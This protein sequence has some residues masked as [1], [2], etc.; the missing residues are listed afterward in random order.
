MSGK[1]DSLLS[2]MTLEEKTSMLAGAD[3][4]HT[5]PVE[6][7]GIPAIKVSDG[8]IGARGANES[9]GPTSAAFP[10]GVALAATWNPA[11][12]ERVG[13]ALAQ[14]VKA[15]GAHI[16]LAPT[17]NI[18]R[19]PLAGR[20]FECYSE[21]P[22]L[23][24]RMA[25]AY[26]MG[27]Q[28]QGVGACI[29]HFV[30]N[31]S[32]FERLT[33]SS[34]VGERALREIYLRPFQIAL[35]EAH[36]WAVM[37][38]YNKINGTWAS[39]NDYTLLDILKGEWGFDGL[40]ISDWFGTNTPNVVR[41]GLDLEMPGPAR[42]MG[43]ASGAVKTGAV[44]EAAIDDKVRRL[45]RTLERAGA[46]E[47]PKLEAEQA[48]DRPEHRQLAREA[49]AEAIVLLKNHADILPIDLSRRGSIAVIGAN[50]HWAAVMGGGSAKV[51]P[52]YVVTPLEG[53]RQ[54]TGAAKVGYAIG[55][56][57][58]KNPPLFDAAWLRSE[59]NAQGLTVRYFD[60]RVLIGEPVHTAVTS[61][62]E[63]VWFG[64]KL[65]HINDTGN[66]SL[67]LNGTFVAP[68]AGVYILSLASV[69]Q[70]RLFLDGQP[71]IDLWEAAAAELQVFESTA[72]TAEVTLRAGQACRLVVEFAAQPGTIWRNLRLGCMPP[73]PADPLGEAMA[74][75]RDSDVAIVFAGLTTEWESEGYDRPDMALPGDQARLIEAV[76]VANPRTIVVLNSGAPV[77]MGWLDKVA[78]VLQAWYPG[79]EAG[80]AIADVLFGDVN[81]SGKLPTTFPVRLEDTPAYINYPGENGR[82]LYGEGLFVGYRYYDKK[83][84]TPLFPFGHGLSY[85]SF[86][87]RNLSLP[88]PGYAAGLPIRLSVDVENI[89]AR[90][91]QEVVQVYIRDV[92]S[93]LVRPEKELK[94][95]AKVRLAPGET[96]TVTFTLDEDALAYYDPSQPGWVTEA[97]EFEVLVGSSSRDIRL[98]G[99]FEVEL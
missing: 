14:E 21:D 36:P 8:P 92:R 73:L 16:L 67:R 80:N 25:T 27:L 28:S 22:Y 86:A 74:L 57:M 5:T 2:R 71:I 24:G 66:F 87:Y 3:L 7:L 84:V 88:V 78:A 63:L 49:A 17:V 11:L 96:R 82:V 62:M 93:R 64:G 91:G 70:S 47:H 81:P 94:A 58:H 50:A 99:A 35:R 39:E 45:L 54:R 40:V 1:I 4:W 65:P 79:Q 51:H 72:R 43:T 13:R 89:G 76:A 20:N 10:A 12:V 85:T 18:H 56:P 83:D 31:D 37:S 32:E 61:R 52:H 41:S 33:M 6:R 46:F 9:T 30:C 69:G 23:S 44:S 60:N 95:F 98:T 34:E 38:A 90:P 19:S 29:K 55:C 77:D 15:K 75:A 68:A 42:W 53:I 59:D 97:G 48:L 26:I